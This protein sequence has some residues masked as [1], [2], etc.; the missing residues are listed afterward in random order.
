VIPRS[1]GDF[2]IEPVEFSYYDIQN[3]RYRTLRTQP[4]KLKVARSTDVA[5]SGVPY[6]PGT[7]R[8]AVE[9]LG[10]DIRYIRTAVPSWR[11]TGKYLTGSY[12][13]FVI[14]ALI[15][16]LTG[17]VY[18]VMN[19]RR[20]HMNDTIRV[21]NSKANKIARTRLKAAGMLL[22]QQLF[23]AY[24]EELHRA[25]WG[26]IADKLGLSQADCSRDRIS[27]MLRD[28]NIDKE[29]IQNYSDIIESCEYARYAPDPGQLEK[30]R[31]FEAAVKAISKM[32]QALK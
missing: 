15:F 16:A 9:S 5:A 19:K 31:I 24:Y 6:T 28:R 14:L 8:R 17:V 11:T 20:E 32:E 22:K 3:K 12:L 10:K 18:V 30:E 25:L 7:H 2:T 1:H 13:Y 27:D 21:R 29:L 26:Y 23:E 4:I